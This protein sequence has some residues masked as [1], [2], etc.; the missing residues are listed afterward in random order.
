[1]PRENLAL[2]STIRHRLENI[3]AGGIVSEVPDTERYGVP[4]T[5]Y[6]DVTVP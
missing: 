3:Q 1:M 5:V 4:L 2:A 6:G